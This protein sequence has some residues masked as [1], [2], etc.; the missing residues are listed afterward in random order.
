MPPEQ[1]VQTLRQRAV[2]FSTLVDTNISLKI[3]TTV[4]GKEHRSPSLGGDL[5]FDSRLP[6]LWLHTEK[7]GHEIFDLKALAMDFSLKL[8]SSG[9]LVT[10]GPIAYA[11]LPYLIRPDEV[12]TMFAGPDALGLS[13]PT[14]TVEAGSDGDSFRVLV[15][16]TLFRTVLVDPG[17]A[18]ILQVRDYDVLGRI[19]TDITLSDYAPFGST[20]F[21]LR[22]SVDRPL[23]GVRM[24]LRLG[25]TK[26]NKPI[27]LKAF[28]PHKLDGY[29]HVDLDRQPLSD[30]HAFSGE[31]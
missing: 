23:D 29:R 17:T 10:G 28:Q 6:G 22:L 3:T 19:V 30:V 20:R 15:Y 9:E 14:T 4:D 11:K 13:W 7:V 2:E 21:P 18:D 31:Q 24:D 12:Q 16:G 1:I 27:E 8:P 5:A 25:E 26:L